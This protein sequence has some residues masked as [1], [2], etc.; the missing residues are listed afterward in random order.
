MSKS[1]YHVGSTLLLLGA[2]A[3]GAVIHGVFVEQSFSLASPLSVFGLVAGLA[4]ILFGRRLEAGHQA[5][6]LSN[7][8]ESDGEDA[9]VEFD[10]A[11]APFDEADLEKYERDDSA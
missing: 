4:L 6:L 7:E 10:E 9:E 5:S 8:D 3:I 1:G 2:F 11:A